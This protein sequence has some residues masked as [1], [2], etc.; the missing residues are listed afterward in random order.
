MGVRQRI[1]RNPELRFI[2]DCDDLIENVAAPG[3]RVLRDCVYCGTACIAGLCV[4]RVF[5]F[6]GTA[7][8]L[9]LGVWRWGVCCVG[10]VFGC[11]RLLG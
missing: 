4:L 6:C 8:I 5:V 3:Q 11:A 1:L 7:F 9:V 10:G 2:Q